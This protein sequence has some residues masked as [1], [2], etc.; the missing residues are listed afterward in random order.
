MHPKDTDGMAKSVDPDQSF[1]STVFAQI[2]QSE[3]VGS[4][5]KAEKMASITEIFLT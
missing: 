3:N 5:W 2:W 1:V 4:L